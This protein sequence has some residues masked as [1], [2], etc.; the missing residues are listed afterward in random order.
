MKYPFVACS[1]R[2]LIRMVLASKWFSLALAMY[3][4][5]L[6]KMASK[7]VSLSSIE[8][9]RSFSLVGF[10]GKIDF[11]CFTELFQVSKVWLPQRV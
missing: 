4:K 5:L 3:P 6:S 7:T 11:L 1:D 8:F 10:L 9:A 2:K